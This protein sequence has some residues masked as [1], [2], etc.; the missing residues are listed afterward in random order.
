MRRALVVLLAWLTSLGTGC[1]TTKDYKDMTEVEKAA[2]ITKLRKKAEEALSDFQRSDGQDLESLQEYVELQR[3][4]T[5]VAPATCPLCFYN[6]AMGL[7]RLGLYYRDLAALFEAEAGKAASAGEKEEVLAKAAKYREEMRANMLLSNRQFEIYFGSGEAI[8]P[9]AYSWV[10]RQCQELGDFANARR[11]LD[12]YLANVILDA[13]DQKAADEIRRELDDQARR[14]LED[15]LRREM[16]GE[17]SAGVGRR[18][19][20]RL[21]DVAN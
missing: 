21:P 20:Q 4:T 6:Y 9:R 3:E 13:D 16:E 11:Y 7:S 19:P 18:P 8:D 10:Y 5:K 17:E 14:Q 2:Q 15:E 1:G 12:R